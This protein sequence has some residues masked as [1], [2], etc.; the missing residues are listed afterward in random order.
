MIFPLCPKAR[1]RR[2]E[3]RPGELMTAALEVFAERGF[4]AARLDDVAKRA[5]VSKGTVYLY[6]DSKEAL[7]K[8]AVEAAA[9]PALEGVEVIAGDQDRRP[10]EALR[11]FVFWWWEQ[12]GSGPL[13]AL[14]KLLIGEIGNFPE[15][16]CWFHDNVIAR[17]M[18]AAAAIIERG[19][20]TGDFR[21]VNAM[22]VARLVFA[23]MFS[24]VVWRRAFGP[25]MPDLPEPDAYFNQVLDVLI[26]GLAKAQE[27][28]Q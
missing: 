28:P 6:F 4:A 2:K 9:M 16:G 1:Q 18:R 25:A 24:Y 11:D 23:Q 5:G 26:N 22:D 7:F 21:Q 8:A 15:L 10:P 14:P 27:L 19:I 3:A 12:I 17:A 13:G 20:A